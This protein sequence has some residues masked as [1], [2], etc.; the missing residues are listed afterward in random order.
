MSSRGMFSIGKAV[1]WWIMNECVL[2]IE[3]GM[4]LTGHCY[5]GDHIKHYTLMLWRVWISKAGQGSSPL[6]KV[7]QRQFKF[8]F[9]VSFV[10]HKAQLSVWCEFWIWRVSQHKAEESSFLRQTQISL[11][12]PPS[13]E[14]NPSF[15]YFPVQTVSSTGPS[16]LLVWTA[17]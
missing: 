3:Y 4:A 8:P 6:N 9:L 11:L 2:N 10:N 1:V 14:C 15:S 16:T 17:N 5:D 12:F 13:Q 7:H